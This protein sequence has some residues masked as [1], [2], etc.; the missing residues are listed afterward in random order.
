[1]ACLRV[2]T[3]LLLVTHPWHFASSFR[4]PF[5]G[6]V[7]TSVLPTS[8]AASPWSSDSSPAANGD[9]GHSRANGSWWLGFGSPS[10]CTA[11]ALGLDLGFGGGPRLPPVVGYRHL[12]H[13]LPPSLSSRS[14]SLTLDL[15]LFRSGCGGAE[16]EKQRDGLPP[17]V[18]FF[19]FWLFNHTY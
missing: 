9:G 6:V 2:L 11:P 19:L 3:L 1:M 14:P 13:H 17:F 8:P 12:C 18:L 7:A 4:T 10:L 15:S 5:N 16:K